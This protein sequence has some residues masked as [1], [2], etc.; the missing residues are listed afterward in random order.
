MLK[1]KQS[2]NII[3]NQIQNIYIDNWID[4]GNFKKTTII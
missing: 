2:G 1:A 3:K 4:K